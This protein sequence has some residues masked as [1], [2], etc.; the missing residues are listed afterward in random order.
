MSMWT[1]QYR[2]QY[3][4]DDELTFLGVFDDWDKAAKVASALNVDNPIIKETVVN[5]FSDLI[6]NGYFPFVIDV[7]KGKTVEYTVIA[8]SPENMDRKTTHQIFC[9][10]KTDELLRIQCLAQ[11][12]ADAAQIVAKVMN[13]VGWRL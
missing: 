8:R 6:D 1:V 7:K 2:E 4:E 11:S 5:P 13:E 3:A 12:Q 10:G 9:K